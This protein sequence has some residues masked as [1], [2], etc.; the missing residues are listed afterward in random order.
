MQFRLAVRLSCAEL[1]T[2]RVNDWRAWAYPR[3]ATLT[4]LTTP[5]YASPRLLAKVRTVIPTARPFPGAAPWPGD[6]LY[7]AAQADTD[8][9]A[10]EFGASLVNAVHDS[11]A[12]VLVA[13]ADKWPLAASISPL[14]PFSSSLLMFHSPWWTIDRGTPTGLSI[15]D[16]EPTVPVGIR[17]LATHDGRI[18]DSFFP[19][20]GPIPGACAGSERVG[21]SFFVHD[22]ATQKAPKV[23]GLQVWM[24][25]IFGQDFKAPA[26]G[27]TTSAAPS[28]AI[29]YQFPYGKGEVVV[30]GL[31]LELGTCPTPAPPSACHSKSYPYPNVHPN[32]RHARKPSP[33]TT[34]LT[35]TCTTSEH[36]RLPPRPVHRRRS[37]SFFP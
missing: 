5:V 32:T 25:A 34:A 15:P 12:R 36:R 21:T 9:K 31:E 17:S 37:R 18:D 30:S 3:A 16:N 6:A 28:N 24:E 8:P 4:N 14:N 13:Q 1:E 35:I 33:Q 10:S 27:G 29:V 19:A 23:L 7:I 20:L 26:V 22:S 2:P 11:G